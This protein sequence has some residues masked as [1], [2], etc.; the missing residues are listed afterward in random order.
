MITACFDFRDVDFEFAK[1]FAQLTGAINRDF[2]G[3][4][5]AIFEAA[6]N[7]TIT[8]TFA[9]NGHRIAFMCA[10]RA[11]LEHVGSEVLLSVLC[12]AKLETVLAT[13]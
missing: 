12:D 6:E 1:H 9:T 11:F 2:L 10:C 5:P 4:D 13:R 8:L 3:H 7:Q